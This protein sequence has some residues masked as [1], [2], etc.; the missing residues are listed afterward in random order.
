MCGGVGVGTV[1]VVVGGALPIAAAGFDLERS[2]M[3][4]DSLL[5]VCSFLLWLH[6]CSEIRFW[7]PGCSSDGLLYDLR[8]EFDSDYW[9]PARTHPFFVKPHCNTS[10]ES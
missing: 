3:I 6:V 9:A 1:M 10:S 5:A 4:R 7:L 2:E 8:Y